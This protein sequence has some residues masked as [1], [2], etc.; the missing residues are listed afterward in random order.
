MLTL[1]RAERGVTLVELMIGLVVMAVLL[2]AGIPSF[3]NWIQGAHIRDTAESLQSGL[4]LARAEAVRRNTAVRLE[5]DADT[6]W[7]VGCD[8]PL[9]DRDGDG[10]DDCPAAIQ[11]RPA[12][13]GGARASVAMSQVAAASGATAVAPDA[14]SVLVFNGLGRVA[15]G[16]ATGNLAVF[17][18]RNP[19]GG[20]CAPEGTMRC[21]RVIVTTA[22]QVRMC[23]P[24]VAAGDPRG[25]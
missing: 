24:A 7:T 25:C 13:G 2:A 22:G 10:A 8:V 1:P 4:N 5:L 15:S 16:L 3:G 20:D 14:T 12:S 6:S 18:I 11:A 19:G 9:N 17:D 21:L 23:D